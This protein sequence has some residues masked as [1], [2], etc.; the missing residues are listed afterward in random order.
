MSWNIFNTNPT[1]YFAIISKS[2]NNNA[3]AQT[4]GEEAPQ[5]TL[6]FTEQTL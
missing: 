1:P 3:E 5:A 4:S 2:R 6:H